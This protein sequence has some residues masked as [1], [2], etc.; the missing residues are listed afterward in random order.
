MNKKIIPFEK[1][2]ASHPKC[3]FWSTKNEFP[4]EKYALKSHSKCWFDCT[5]CGHTFDAILKNI[6]RID[7]WCTYCHHLKLCENDNCNSCFQKSF[8]AKSKI[9]ILVK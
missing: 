6:N 4:P 2:F 1:S 7:T 5:E 9:Y 3:R 8:A